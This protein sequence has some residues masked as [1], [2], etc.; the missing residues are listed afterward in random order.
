MD[1][2]LSM[3]CAAVALTRPVVIAC[4]FWNDLAYWFGGAII[5][6]LALAVRKR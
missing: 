4:T 6:S 3:G 5:C 2:S 1:A